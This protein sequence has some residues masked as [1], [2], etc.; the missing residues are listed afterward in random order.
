MKNIQFKIIVNKYKDLIYNHAYYY[1]ANKHD[2]EDIAQEVFIKLWHNLHNIKLHSVKAWLLKVTRNL[3]I[4]YS[5][6]KKPEFINENSK[7]KNI[8]DTQSNPENEI[9]NKDLFD[10]IVLVIN[11]LPDKMRS[12]VVMRDIQDLKYETIAHTMDL[13]L[14]SVKVYLHRGRKLLH[15]KL[16]HNF[17]ND[18]Q[19]E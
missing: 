5:R 12:V 17:K 2:A 19:W 16:S 15:K 18:F 1:T 10:N 4:D 7:Y 3:C 13:P 8:I 6:Q 14:N 9:I 11:Q